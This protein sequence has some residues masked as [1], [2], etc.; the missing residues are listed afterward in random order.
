MNSAFDIGVEYKI[1]SGQPDLH[2]LSPQD[3]KK[4]GINFVRLQWVDLTNTVRFRVMPVEYLLKLLAAKRGGINIAKVTLGLVNLSVAEGFTPM[5]EYLYVPDIRTLRPCPFEHGHA[6][7]LGWFEEKAPYT[8]PGGSLSV[9]VAVCPR[10][11]LKKIVDRAEKESHAKFL[12]GFESE[13]VLLKS[14]RPFLTV[15]AHAFSTS[16]SLRSGDIATKVMNDIAKAV[17]ASGIELQLYHGEA[18][19]GQYEV[20]TGPLPPLESADALVHTREIIYNIAASYGLRATFAP[21]TTLT[22]AGSGAHVHISVHSTSPSHH[23]PKTPEGLSPLEQSFLAGLMHHLPALPALTLPTAASYSR[24]G[25]GVWSG[26]TYVCW[27]T[28][29]REAPVRL[30]NP[31]SPS[32]RR[33]ELRFI[34]GTASP[35]L[36]LAG[37]VAAG[38]AG[39]KNKREL[40][41]KDCPGPTT[42]AQMTEEER[43]AMGITKRMPL[44]W[45]EGRRRFVEDEE[46]VRAFG[47]EMREKYLSVNKL[48]N[49]YLEGV[50]ETDAKL[51]RLVKFY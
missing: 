35:Y 42:A 43:M 32:S 20:V 22:S 30:T 10:T 37:V 51:Q 18:A 5:G 26:G 6:S 23:A 28:E 16:E 50:S 11:I 1:S 19:P 21:K 39:I 33:F 48:A 29:N 13:F 8:L 38:H 15:G 7:L 40:N 9:E 31:A 3:L 4:T 47:E 17:Q 41:V 25:D 24:V 49:E 45:E 12:V 2:V 44:S 14:S 46:I 27:G 36:A 34:D